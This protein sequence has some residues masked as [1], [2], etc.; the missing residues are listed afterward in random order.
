MQ[1]YLLILFVTLFI[2]GCSHKANTRRSDFSTGCFIGASA[3]IQTL[4]ANPNDEA[5]LDYCLHMYD[6]N[7]DLDSKLD[8]LNKH[9]PPKK[10]YIEIDP[11]SRFN[12][13]N[14]KTLKI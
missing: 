6:S 5:L 4:G 11:A 9:I 7:P 13:N 3:I 8:E 2:F 14:N 1:K 12:Y 10:R